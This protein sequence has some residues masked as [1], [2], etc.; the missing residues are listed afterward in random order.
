MAPAPGVAREVRLLLDE[1]H[2]PSIAEHLVE[3]SFDVI[4]V[5]STPS[6]RGMADEDLLA[7]AAGDGR[8]VVTENVV[9]FTRLSAAWAAAGKSHSG[10]VFTNPRRFNRAT[11]AYPG[12]MIAALG[13]FLTEAPVAGESWTWW[14]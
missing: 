3:L 5:C 14:L 9:D 4:A 1:M 13:D 7:H 2:A 12:N 11:L 8:S 6:L 10:L